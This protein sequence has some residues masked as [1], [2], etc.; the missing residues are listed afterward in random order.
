MEN[1]LYASIFSTY[2]QGYDLIT[3]ASK[4]EGWNVDLA[5]ISRIWEGG[6][7]IRA[8][9]LTFLHKAFLE[10]SGETPHLF[11]IPEVTNALAQSLP[12]WHRSV[13]IMSEHG[14]AIPTISSSL[15]YFEGIVNN[16]HPANYLQGLRDFFGAHTYERTD[17]EGTFHTQWSE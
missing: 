8:D 13:G 9:I 11:M 16:N 2:A 6:C 14:I 15:S 1:G 7:I 12:N 17:R 10:N 3:Q 4:T 5:E